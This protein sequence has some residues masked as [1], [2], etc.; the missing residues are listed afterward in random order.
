MSDFII[1]QARPQDAIVMTRLIMMAM[2]EPC[3]RYFCG[4][5]H[6]LNEFE[7]MMQRL[8]QSPDSQYS[9]LNALLAE[10]GNAVCGIALTYDGAVLHQLRQA[11]IQAAKE[12]FGIDYSHI[13][14]ET[15]D[16]E[17]YLDSFAVL[18]DCRKKGIG[19]ALLHA[20]IDKARQL[21]IPRLGLLVDDG[22][23]Q[24]LRLYLNFGFKQVGINSWGG[25]SMK[26]LQIDA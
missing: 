24:A 22:N 2:T 10:Q 17:L 25:H 14:D 11:F 9:Y 3:C 18:P 5:E 15:Q 19:T 8:C 1:R 6:T 13:P 26:H 12:A 4:P 20:S 23:P 21:S 16:G 7:S